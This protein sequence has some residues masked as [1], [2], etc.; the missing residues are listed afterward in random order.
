[1]ALTKKGKNF[2][3]EPAWTTLHVF[4]AT[5]TPDKKDEFLAFVKILPVLLPCPKCGN[6]FRANAKKYD[7]NR[8]LGNN[9]ELFFWGYLMH[10]A[11]NQAHNIEVANGSEK[12]D[13]TLKY[14]PPFDE[15]KSFYFRALSEECK[16]C[17]GE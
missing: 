12:I 1:M 6:H 8:Y 14:S 17:Q 9:H 7:V 10:D 3:G 2:W 4:T 15:V 11:V 13:T 16:A 5:Y